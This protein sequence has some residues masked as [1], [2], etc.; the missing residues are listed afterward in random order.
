M[1][2]IFTACLLLGVATFN[3]YAEVFILY[4]GMQLRSTAGLDAVWNTYLPDS[5]KEC[6]RAKRG[7]GFCRKVSG[8]TN[9]SLVHF[10]S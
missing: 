5:L 1:T 10:M 3:D 8:L 9:Y 2:L 4:L 7:N 6:T